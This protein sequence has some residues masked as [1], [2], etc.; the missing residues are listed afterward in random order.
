MID[1][2]DVSDDCPE[3]E[4]HQLRISTQLHQVCG[5]EVGL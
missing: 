5:D 4:F 1:A 3:S 2:F